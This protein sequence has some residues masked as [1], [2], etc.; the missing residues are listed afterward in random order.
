MLQNFKAMLDDAYKNKYAV[1]SF[2][3]Y[4]YETMKGAIEASKKMGNKPLIIAFGAK[5]LTNMSLGDVKAMAISLLNGSDIPVCLHLDHCSDLETIYQ[6]ISAGFGSVMYDG[7]SLP[8]EE[9]LKN[10]R[11]VC[12]VA[13]S[14]GIT[15]E[16][17]L[18]SLASGDE[19]HEGNENDV[20]RYTDPRLAKEFVEYTGVD[21]LAV[22]IGTVHGMY[23]GTPNIRIDILSEINKL[24]GIPLVLH[25]GS[26][27]PEGDIRACIKNGI[28]KIN[29]NTEISTYVVEKTME[30]LSS[31]KKPHLSVLAL[32]QKQLVSEVVEK[33]IQ[34][35]E[36]ES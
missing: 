20:E 5:Y 35:F 36:G 9:N 13:H 6:A 15:V 27:T 21:A 34:F 1:G 33:Y 18:G 4:N 8:F 28:S 29:V 30:I 10:T 32:M 2:N 31:Q 23:K 24:T 14:C 25:G 7:S 17:E 11:L 19:S 26:G 3:I 22:S 16:A 12:D